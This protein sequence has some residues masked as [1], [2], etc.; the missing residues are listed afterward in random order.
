MAVIWQH[1]K[2]ESCYEVRKAGESLRL[3]TNGVFHSQYNDQFPLAGSVW[4]LLVLPALMK[5]L[6][7]IKRVLILG[8]GA[9]AV[10]RQLQ[11]L[12]QPQLVVG[13]EW[14]DVHLQVAEKLFEV[15]QRSDVVLHCVNAIHWLEAYQGPAFDLIIEDLFVEK[16]SEPERAVVADKAWCGLLMQNLSEAGTL[17]MNFDSSSALNTCAMQKKPSLKKKVSAAYRLQ[18]PR[19]DNR[20][21]AFLMGQGGRTQ[22]TSN[23]KLLWSQH[24]PSIIQRMRT[25]IDGLV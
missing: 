6:G 22:L 7:S 3:Y 12:V 5:P 10:I 23:L 20:V 9:G 24:G 15:K 4:D 13:I 16:D 19:Y 2:G 11:R 25:K 17:V 21:G 14:D 18:V 1:T 8:V